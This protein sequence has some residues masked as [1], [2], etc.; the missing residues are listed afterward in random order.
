MPE[1][2][3][4]DRPPR[5]SDTLNLEMW[6]WVFFQSDT[7]SDNPA[8]PIWPPEELGKGPGPR[9]RVRGLGYGFSL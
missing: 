5:K 6:G 2:S 1:T 3:E 9:L 7:Q 8:I 4:S